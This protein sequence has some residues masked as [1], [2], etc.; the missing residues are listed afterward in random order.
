MKNAKG[1][2]SHFDCSNDFRKIFY[3]THMRMREPKIGL[4]QDVITRWNS[5]FYL[6]DRLLKCQNVLSHVAVDYKKCSALNEV[7]FQKLED[8]AAIL[9]PFEK[10]TKT[11]SERSESISS[12]LPAYFALKAHLTSKNDLFSET[13]SSGL[14]R[15][16]HPFLREKFLILATLID[17]RY[18]TR[19]FVE[20]FEKKF[21]CSL[22]ETELEIMGLP[23]NERSPSPKRLRHI[24]RNAADPIAQ[25][26][27]DVGDDI[28]LDSESN[29]SSAAK[30]ELKQYLLE[31]PIT[32]DC[33]PM[34]YWKTKGNWP[35]LQKIARKYL[36]AP[37][38]SVESERAFSTLGGIYKPKRSS[39]T[40]EHAREQLF[41]HHHL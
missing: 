30:L 4:I 20:E 39:L 36:S 33:D 1:I 5:T 16:M 12:V 14:T 3:D 17:P 37:P 21:A 35:N 8:L 24:S 11:M 27:G 28:D 26:L 29:I 19:G 6:I 25:F 41:L 40:G 34:A 18:K 10:V 7:D 23:E 32:R 22:L 2:V 38:S 31:Q 15:R 9:A 13:V